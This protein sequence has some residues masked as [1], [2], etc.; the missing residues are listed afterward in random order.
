[1][2]RRLALRI[3]TLL[4]AL[5]GA[6]TA[7]TAHADATKEATPLSA[8][9][10][11]KLLAFFGELVDTAAKHAA[12]CAAQA[13]AVDGVV[14]RHLNT[15]QMMWAA[16]KAKKVVPRDVQEKLDKRALE[17]VSA[18]R[19]CWDHDGVKKAFQR[20][21]PPKAQAQAGP[22]AGRGR[23]RGEVTRAARR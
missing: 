18:L 3:V 15:L 7:G 12:D 11:E 19:K 9:D 14:T 22:A 13:G 21:K 4:I 1:M 17:M 2:P 5:A 23:G 8:A 20:M 6:G 16:R 10:S